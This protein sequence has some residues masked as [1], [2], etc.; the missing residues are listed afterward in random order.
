MA[1]V[2]TENLRQLLAPLL[3]EV[4]E[5]K[6]RI[7]VIETKGVSYRGQFNLS[8]DY[9]RGDLVTYKGSIFHAVRDVAGDFPHRVDADGQ[10]RVA[11]AWQLAVH[12]G[13]DAR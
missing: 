10:S 5:L 11:D 2:T 6:R 12:K 1:A 3:K 9:K 13:R 8:D 4:G 7:A